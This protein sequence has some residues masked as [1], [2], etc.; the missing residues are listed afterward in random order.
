MENKKTT[1]LLD[2][3]D[4]AVERDGNLSDD[5]ETIWEELKSRE[6]FYT[7]LNEDMEESIPWLV[8]EIENLKQDIKK[9]KRHN[10][11]EGRV[12]ISI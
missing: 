1:E 7:I 6:P 3:L 8:A 5:W 11:H 12:V 4:K 9:L 2:L 10:H